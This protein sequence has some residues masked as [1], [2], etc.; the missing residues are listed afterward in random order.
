MT[1]AQ[2]MLFWG[3]TLGFPKNSMPRPKSLGVISV[4]ENLHNVSR[5]VS[6]PSSRTLEGR[7]KH[8]PPPVPKRDKAKSAPIPKRTPPPSTVEVIKLSRRCR[9]RRRLTTAERLLI[10]LGQCPA[11]II[12]SARNYEA[13]RDRTPTRI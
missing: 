7:E 3:V 13:G 6:K 12:T 9:R 11:R 4:H 2:K 5:V 1:I 10:A 8:R